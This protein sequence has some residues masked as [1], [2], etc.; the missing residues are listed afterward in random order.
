[1][2]IQIYCISVVT[3]I[4]DIEASS[5]F[6][7]LFLI[8]SISFRVYFIACFSAVHSHDDSKGESEFNRAKQRDRASSAV[9]SVY[10]LS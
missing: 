4:E 7:Q 6:K 2:A 1:M 3:P 9:S 10:C 8:L 5:C